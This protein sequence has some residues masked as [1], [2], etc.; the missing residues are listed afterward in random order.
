[1]VGLVLCV[2]IGGGVLCYSSY[3]G[4]VVG[5]VGC[6]AAAADVGMVLVLGIGVGAWTNGFIPA[7]DS[8]GFCFVS[9]SK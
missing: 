3:G 7:T 2:L 4:V 9:G 1:M 6:A 5:V 8:V